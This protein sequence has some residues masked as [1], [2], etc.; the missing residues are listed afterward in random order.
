[1]H[2]PELLILYSLG[3]ELESDLPNM[4]A[5]LQQTLSVCLLRWNH[6][7]AE[8]GCIERNVNRKFGAGEISEFKREIE[9]FGLHLRI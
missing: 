5:G 7:P 1:L 2:L 8:D 3:A 4:C 9:R 6:D